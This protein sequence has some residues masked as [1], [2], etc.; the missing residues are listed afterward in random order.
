M[1]DLLDPAALMRIQSLELRAKVV[2]EG[3]MTGMHRSPWH[4]FS[5]EFSEYRQYTPGDDIRHLDWRVYGRSDKYFI[6]K[7]EDETNLRVQ[8]ILDASRSMQFGSK[9]AYA[10]T[11]AATLATF[12][13]GQGDAVGACTFDED[14]GDYIPPRNRPG[15]LRRLML[16]LEKTPEGQATAFGLPLQRISEMQ[17]KR[18]MFILISDLLAP[19]EELEMRLG[20]LRA[21]GNEVAVFQVLD[22]TELSLDF[23]TASLFEDLETGKKIVVDPASARAD[24]QRHMQEH[25]AEVDG[26]CQRLG[27]ACHRVLTDEPMSKALHTFL[28]ER[29][30]ASGGGNTRR[31]NPGGGA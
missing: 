25:L 24:Y 13:A 22:P 31:S 5:V 3:F 16:L 14:L 15:H 11:L 7:Y 20:F 30:Q 12:I 23:D 28:S 1:P 6:K 9:A 21:R 29:L 26:I 17:Q 10:A 18:G 2:V 4:G 8:L 27:I 19:L